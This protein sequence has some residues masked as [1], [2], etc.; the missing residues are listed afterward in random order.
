MAI[1]VF[2][3]E[4]GCDA[5]SSGIKNSKLRIRMKNSSQLITRIIQLVVV[6]ALCAVSAINVFASPYASG[7]TRTNGAGVVSFIMNEDGATVNVVFEDNTTNS[8]GVLPKGSTNF[9]IGAHTSF[10]IFC[11]KQGTGTPS[12]ISSEAVGSRCRN[13]PSTPCSRAPS[14][15]R[16]LASRASGLGR[17]SFRSTRASAGRRSAH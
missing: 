11:Y 10:R 14:E 6:A 17:S 8:M 7:I 9:N 5:A 2:G 1:L 4:C 16:R 13:R 3:A 15:P 12:I